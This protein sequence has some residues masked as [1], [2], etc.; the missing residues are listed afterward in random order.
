MPV[1]T[2]LPSGDTIEVSSGVTLLKAAQKAGI[3][4]PW[5]C[6]G[7]GVCTTCRCSVEDG[8]NRLSEKKYDEREILES[9]KFD[10]PWRLA[11]KARVYKSIVV[12][13]PPDL[14]VPRE[15]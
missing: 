12:N 3:D 11:C 6:G 5:V 2:F 8:A 15:S 4:L 1:V 10:D 14:A 13:I 7:N 9:E